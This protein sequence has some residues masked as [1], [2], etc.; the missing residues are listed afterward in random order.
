MKKAVISLVALNVWATPVTAHPVSTC[1][2]L[3]RKDLVSHTI[4]L[5]Q[6][7]EKLAH[8]SG[9]RLFFVPSDF[10]GIWVEE[11]QLNYASVSSALDYLKKKY[12]IQYVIQNQNLS[13]RRSL[14]QLSSAG[15][16]Y[17]PASTVIQRDTLPQK[18][19]QLDEVV[20][21]GYGKQKK[22][23]ITGSVAQ[24]KTSDM[25]DVATGNISENI[26]G[27]VAGVQIVQG[28]ARPGVGGSIKMRGTSTINAGSNPLIVV[29]GFPLTEG[30]TLSSIDPNA[31]ESM[32]F[33]KDAASTAIYGSRG[34]NGVIMIKTK[35]GKKGR[36][37]VS[38]NSYQGF[39]ER[40]D[41]VKLLDAY[42][43]AQYQLEARN[44]G[45]VSKNPSKRKESDTNAQRLANGASKRELIPDFLLPYLNKQPGLANTDWL[46]MVFRVAPVIN[47]SINL[48][49]GAEKVNYS[50]TTNYFKQDG[51][52][53]GTDFERLSNAL[54]INLNLSSRLKT[55]LSMNTSFSTENTFFEESGWNYN[56]LD[57][58]MI[59]YPF[60]S[61]YHP[62]GSLAISDQIRKN[63]ETDGALVENPLAVQQQVQSR[64]RSFRI[65]GNAYLDY[66]VAEGLN[67]KTSVGGDFNTYQ[68]NYFH[69]DTVGRYR[70]S[71]GG[72]PTE[73]RRKYR[74]RENFQVENLL[75]YNRKFGQHT[76]EAI[77]GQSYQQERTASD[78]IIAT[79][80]PDNSIENIS[81][82]SQFTVDAGSGRWS[83][84]SYF[85]R[86]NYG[87]AGRYLI[88]ASMRRDGS[89]RFGENAKFAF[90]P[91]FS[92]G[93]IL[94][95][96][97]FFPKNRIL[98]YL[99]LRA[100]WGRS[101][102]NQI[103]NFGARALLRGLDYNFN[104]TLSPGYVT[105][106]SPNPNLTWESAQSTNVG[107]DLNFYDGAF[108]LNIDM[109]KSL[110]D[111]LLLDV[112]VPSQS[113][114]TSSLQNIGKMENTGLELQVSTLKPLHLGGVNWTTSLN[115]SMNRNRVLALAPGQSQI[116]TGASQFSITQVGGPLSQMYGYEVVGV[117]KNQA[118]IQNS[119][120]LPGTLVG[121]YIVRD[122]NGDG[123]I[124]I[125]D[126][127]TF[128]TAAPE[129]I[130]GWNNTF[131]Y[132][133]F[134]LS[135]NFYGEYGRMIFSRTLNSL[136][137]A[138]EGFSMV[139]YDYFNNRY[140]P[141][142][143][144][145]GTMAMPNL[146]NFSNNRRE[147]RVSNLFMKDASYLRLR[148]L[149]L[150]YNLPSLSLAS[151]GMKS[152]QIYL[153]ANNLFT[154]TRYNGF[155]VDSDSNNPLAQGYDNANYPTVRTYTFGLN[156]NF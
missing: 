53:I 135:V 150:A 119:V 76:L 82:G 75:T 63:N 31:I 105:S 100:S 87:Y 132:Q 62:D 56:V 77:A 73:A 113:G 68:H 108:V 124:D 32:D 122:Q 18:E 140:H 149:R 85:G 121:D 83:M 11:S 9:L 125:N 60:F 112:P 128:G 45:Y 120:A 102:N 13:V 58:A 38:V 131:T 130:G 141:V 154:L 88:S 145:S 3:Q 106:T 71:A 146:G 95:Q 52:L 28:A 41:R 115:T 107:M 92:A 116:L 91:A 78:E 97:T 16:Q 4:S 109:Y 80:F 29:D 79:N 127:R 74:G 147:T 21:V 37:S 39:Q 44:N 134:E 138:G 24:M 93:W 47:Y 96:E 26:I 129:F 43:F 86:A 46:K 5:V 12:G 94:S 72:F 90:F 50:V 110:N 61:P 49:G 57:M 143:N 30:S 55:G 148:T 156:L 117:Y 123:K 142:N 20:I 17:R 155:N 64:G 133:N 51:V 1:S 54:N 98:N 22:Q 42:D 2:M 84:L 103:N 136:L 7:L 137:E 151:I 48:N 10:Q 6:A 25:R 114:Y 152:A 69:P 104:E 23:N 8:T 40:A 14:P 89:S 144:P 81:G 27:K 67:F 36:L 118:E 70:V 66:R 59:S 65:F 153:M 126:K 35:E 15:G 33:L 99:K 34:A 101:G 139:S 19:S 111:G